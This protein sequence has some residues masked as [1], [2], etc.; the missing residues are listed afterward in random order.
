[1]LEEREQKLE[2]VLSVASSLLAGKAVASNSITADASV[3]ND[4]AVELKR[5]LLAD[6][7]DQQSKRPHQLVGS[8]TDG[9]APRRSRYAAL[10]LVLLVSAAAAGVATA[11][12]AQL[13]LGDVAAVVPRLF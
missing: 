10:V 6:A 3:A 2:S 9:Q 4:N 1:L 11:V 5:F 13:D 8:R 12:F 7:L